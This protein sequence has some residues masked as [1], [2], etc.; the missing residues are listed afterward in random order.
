M[1]SYRTESL[2]LYQ[3]TKFIEMNL[4]ME[5]KTFHKQPETIQYKCFYQKHNG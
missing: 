3:N 4:L 5:G 1:G 2:F